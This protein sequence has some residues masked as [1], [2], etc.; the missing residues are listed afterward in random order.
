MRQ[1]RKQIILAVVVVFLVSVAVALAIRS[2][3][4]NDESTVNK[5]IKTQNAKLCESI[6]SIQRSGAVTG[7]AKLT[8]QQAVMECK[9][10]VQLG[11]RPN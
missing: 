3:L 7:A 1:F 9:N 4:P 8:G 5:A 6:K 10:Y 2:F 11:T